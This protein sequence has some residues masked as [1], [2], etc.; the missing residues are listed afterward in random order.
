[1]SRNRM[2]LLADT[3]EKLGVRHES[4]CRKKTDQC[5][6]SGTMLRRHDDAGVY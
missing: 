1:M 3:I 2:L 5:P 4:D 6:P